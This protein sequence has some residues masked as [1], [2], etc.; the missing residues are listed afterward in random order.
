MDTCC[1]VLGDAHARAV[2]LADRCESDITRRDYGYREAEH[3][4]YIAAV[5]HADSIANA[6]IAHADAH[7]KEGKHEPNPPEA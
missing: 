4:S 7:V 6:I 3:R 2:A 1:Q 5:A